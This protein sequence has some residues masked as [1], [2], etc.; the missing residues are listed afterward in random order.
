MHNLLSYTKLQT[1]HTKV[2]LQPCISHFLTKKA[3]KR[4]RHKHVFLLPITATSFESTYFL[5]I[6]T[7]SPSK[8]PSR[9]ATSDYLLYKVLTS[10][11][12]RGF[13]KKI[14][15]QS[16]RSTD[17]SFKSF[18]L[19]NSSHSNHIFAITSFLKQVE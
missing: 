4:T 15:Q 5:C 1:V 3:Q 14:S 12:S 13:C 17:S 2:A 11:L 8:W 16:S 18:F 7:D 9:L 6:L 19:E 10:F